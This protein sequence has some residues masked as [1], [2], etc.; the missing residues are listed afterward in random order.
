LKVLLFLCFFVFW[1]LAQPPP[2]P[3]FKRSTAL[4][5]CLPLAVFN[6]VVSRVEGLDG[7]ILNNFGPKSISENQQKQ[8]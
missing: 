3:N 7:G 6:Y 2:S 8:Q 5:T 1:L 4:S